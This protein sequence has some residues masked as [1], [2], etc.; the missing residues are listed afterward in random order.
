MKLKNLIINLVFIFIIFISFFIFL[1]GLNNLKNI[2]LYSYF[3]FFIAFTATLASLYFLKFSNFDKKINFLTII[4]FSYITLFF[5]NSFLILNDFYNPAVLKEKE[6]RIERAKKSEIQFDE[7]TKLQVIQDLKEKNK[8]AY[9]VMLPSLF[10]QSSKKNDLVSLSGISNS[11]TVYGNETGEYL[12]YLSDRYGFN[13]DDY[14][15]DHDM[16]DY[17]IIG[18][19]FAHGANVAKGEDVASILRKKGYTAVTIGMGA[20]GPL[21][22]LASLIEYGVQFKPKKILWFYFSNDS[23]DLVRELQNPILKKYIT[24][25]NFKQDLL[26]KQKKIDEV[27]KTLH[28]SKIREYQKNNEQRFFKTSYN[29]IKLFSKNNIRKAFTLY[30]IRALLNIDKG[31]F[32]KENRITSETKENFKKIFYK[33]CKIAD[34]NNSQFFLVNLSTFKTLSKGKTFSSTFVEYFINNFFVKRI[35]FGDFLLLQDDFKS[36]FPFQMAGHYTKEGYEELAEIILDN[37][38]N[39]DLNNCNYNKINSIEFL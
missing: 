9:S 5:I 36:F 28:E 33:A 31:A 12:I 29:P 22:E 30:Q 26:S 35:N 27:L 10:I 13:N 4:F 37:T 18:D 16:I 34:K 23:T 25:E 6:K 2:A 38:R 32:I 11:L 19:S 3:L 24:H 7:R 14:I 17:L 20:S 8:T 39:K 15:Y 21:I 1:K